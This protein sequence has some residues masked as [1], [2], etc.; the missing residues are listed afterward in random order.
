MSIAKLIDHSLL[1]PDAA[2]SD[3]LKLCD[4]ANKYGFFAV[5]VHPHYVPITKE[6]LF[7]THV[8]IAAVIGFPH[9][10]T[11]TE[12]KVYEAVQS[13]LRGADELDIVVNAGM[14]KSGDWGAVGKEVSDIVTATPG[15]LHKI[16]VEMCYLT[17]D[18]KKRACATVVEAGAEYIKTSTGF[19]PSGA[20]IE[21]VQ[22]IK[23]V[24]KG[25]LGI[26]AASGISTLSQAKAFIEAGASRIGTSSGVAIIRE[27]R[28]GR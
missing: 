25:R 28:G 14:I 20:V 17:N 2:V 12:V 9:G 21:D 5:C 13:V 23:A 3:I 4:E 11:L 6:A 7:K 8:K 10:M 19:G 1:R 16:I 15:A 24:T 18:E 26:K 22:L 27:D